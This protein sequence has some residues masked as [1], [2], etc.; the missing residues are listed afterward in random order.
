[1][2]KDKSKSKF[3]IEVD[4]ILKPYNFLLVEIENIPNLSDKK[5]TYTESF[6]D[7]LNVCK[8]IRKP[9]YYI[10][11]KNAYNFILFDKKEVYLY[12]LKNTDSVNTLL[13]DKNKDIEELKPEKK[14]IMVRLDDTAEM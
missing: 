7:I 14:F 13:E 2:K 1:M 4:K 5:T 3:Q 11:K 9:I 8:M 6:K 10:V 12:T